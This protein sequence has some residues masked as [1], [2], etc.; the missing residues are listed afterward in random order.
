M[1]FVP[2]ETRVGHVYH[3]REE[4]IKQE[5]REHATLTKILFHGEPP[6]AH[7]VVEPHACPH[8]I[9]ELTDDRKHPLRHVE[10]G[11]YCPQVRST[12]SYALVRSMK[13]TYNGIRFF[14]ANSCSRRTT[15]IMSVVER[16]GRKPLCSS[17]RTPKRS[18]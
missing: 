6:R 3:S 15:N 18:Q 16:F 4:D 13:H 9:V 11:E 17:G 8:A 5:G 1:I 2:L 14:R 10:A 7:A 12:E